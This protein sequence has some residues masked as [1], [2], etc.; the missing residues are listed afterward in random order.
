VVH[1][2][3]GA[4]GSEEW[5]GEVAWIPDVDDPEL[6]LYRGNPAL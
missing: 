2:L 6:E 3:V 1:L 4:A 5:D